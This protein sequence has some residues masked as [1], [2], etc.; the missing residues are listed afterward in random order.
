[1]QPSAYSAMGSA[2]LEPR[3]LVS[4]T[5]EPQTSEALPSN[6]ERKLETPALTECTQRSFGQRLRRSSG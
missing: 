2:K 3:E 6:G 1:M 5:P 4:L